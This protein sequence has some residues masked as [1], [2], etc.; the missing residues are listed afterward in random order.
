MRLDKL[1]SEVLA[2]VNSRSAVATEEQI[3]Q[4]AVTFLECVVLSPIL[5]MIIQIIL[6]NLS[7]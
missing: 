2:G 4:M 5:H 7:E 3:L 6:F 1:R